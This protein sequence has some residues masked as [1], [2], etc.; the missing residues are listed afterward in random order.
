MN[1]PAFAFLL[2]TIL[3]GATSIAQQP[4]PIEIETQPVA[5]GVYMLIGDGGNIG[6]TIGQDGVAIIDDQ[7]DRMSEKIRAAI[8]KLTGQPV[9]F[10]INTHWHGDHTG[11][12]EA[13]GRTGSVIVAHD[14]V[15]RRMSVESVNAFTG[16]T[17][18]AAPRE[19]LPIVTFDQ[20]VTLHYNDDELEVVHVANAHTDGDAVIHFRQANVVHMGDVFFNGFYPFIDNNSGGTLAGMVAAADTV[21][22]RIDDRTRVIPGHG[23][24][25]NKQDL[26]AYRDMLATVHERVSKLVAAGKSQDEVLAAKPTADFDARWGSGFFKPDVWVGRVYVE[27]KRATQPQ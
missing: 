9:S 7:Y 12:N 15:R 21:L 8:G 5:T 23:P 14:N 6:V 17:N 27:L 24:L 16:D 10:V 25:A 11:G 19:A 18:A 4:T 26:Q 1:R 22:A 13:F 2:V 20:A 3:S